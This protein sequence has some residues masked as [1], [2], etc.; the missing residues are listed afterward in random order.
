[1]QSRAGTSPTKNA[2]SCPLSRYLPVLVQA[3]HED[4]S[5][6]ESD[7]ES[8][9]PRDAS[10]AELSL[11]GEDSQAEDPAH[12]Q[13]SEMVQFAA[14]PSRGGG[15][16][17][18]G[19]DAGISTQG[20]VHEE[21]DRAAV[22]RP[23]LQAHILKRALYTAFYS[24]STRALTFERVCY[25]LQ[26]QRTIPQLDE[27]DAEV[28]EERNNFGN[29]ETQEQVTEEDSPSAVHACI[30]TY[31]HTHTNT[32]IHTYIHTYIFEYLYIHV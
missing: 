18:K 30:H 19:A 12:D 32:H 25:V 5:D 27:A 3:R 24:T 4:S 21:G 7:A 26:R 14:R 2:S 20:G 17:R 8:K 31:M 22:G 13:L 16:V 9:R 1:M 29:M 23:G 15:A 28:A 6:A 10:G 11:S